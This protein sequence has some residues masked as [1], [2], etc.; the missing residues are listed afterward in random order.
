MASVVGARLTV[1]VAARFASARGTTLTGTTEANAGARVA[2][3]PGPGTRARPN[4]PAVKATTAAEKIVRILIIESHKYTRLD[5][6]GS[7]TARGRLPVHEPATRL[8][9]RRRRRL[10]HRLCGV[11]LDVSVHQARRR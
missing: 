4:Q 6:L 10:R 3:S 11:G 5:A 9:P 2:E 1:D 8:A 7:Y